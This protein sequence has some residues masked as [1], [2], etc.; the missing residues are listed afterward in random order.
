MLDHKIYEIVLARLKMVLEENVVG[1]VFVEKDDRNY[2]IW[3]QHP[4]MGNFRYSIYAIDEIDWNDLSGDKLAKL[5]MRW[6][7][8]RI[9]KSIFKAR[10]DP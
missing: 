2:Y 8:E 7:K 6:H 3:I 10:N 1:N 4:R 5:V 9:L